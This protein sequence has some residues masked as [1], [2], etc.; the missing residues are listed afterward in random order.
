MAQDKFLIGYSD[1]ESGYQTNLKPWLINDSGFSQLEN[2]YVYRGRVR[3]RFGSTLMGLDQFSSRLRV[4]LGTVA[5]DGT[6]TATVPGTEFNTGQ[7]FSAG[8]DI[9]TV[10]QDGNPADMFVN[11]TG[12]GTYSTI[13]GMLSLADA[14][15]G[16]QVYFYPAT[17]VMGLTLYYRPVTQ[18]NVA[19]F[20]C[21][22]FDTQF[23]YKFDDVNTA[24]ERLDLGESVWT[25]SDYDF[26]WMTNYQG[27]TADLNLLWVTNNTEADGIRYLAADTWN[28]PRLNYTKGDIIGVTP[29]SGPYVNATLL[30]ADVVVGTT[31]TVGLTTFTMRD[32]SL[33]SPYDLE[34]SAGGTGTAT[35]DPTTPGAGIGTLTITG[36]FPNNSVYFT[37]D[38][39]IVTSQIIVQFRNRLLLLNTTERIN[40]VNTFFSNRM[41]Y[42]ANGSPLNADAWFGGNLGLGGA[43]DAPTVQAIV[44]VEFIKDRLIVYFENSTFELAYTGNQIDPFVWQKI[45]TELGAQSTFS[46]IPFDKAV[47]G[48]DDVG[49]HACNGANVERIDQKIPETVFTLNTQFSGVNRVCGIRDYL[50][51]L[52]LWSCPSQNRTNSFYFPNK[53][54]VYNYVNESWSLFDDSFTT[55]G[56]FLITPTSPG[57]TWG[58]TTIKWGENTALWNSNAGST[59]NVKEKRIIAGNQQGFVSI[60]QQDVTTNASV[61]QITNFTFTGIAGV[62]NV[63]CVDHNLEFLDYIMVK[64]MAGLTFTDSDDNVLPEVIVQVQSNTLLDGTP[65]S[66]IGIMVDNTGQPI[67]CTGEYLGGGTAARVSVMAALTKQYNFYTNQDRNAMVNRV[68]FLVD[69]TENGAITVDSFISSTNISMI[70]DLDVGLLPGTNVLETS[71]YLLSTFEQF[72]TRLWHP[73]YFYADGECVQ[74][75]IASSQQQIIGYDVITLEDDTKTYL[76]VSSADFQLHA[77]IFY[78]SPTSYGMQ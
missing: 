50:T 16:A 28:K 73:L 44:T 43:I 29:G 60:I 12:T 66:F 54:L 37:G 31:F 40:G 3:K 24:W 13:D 68:D 58:D 17:P 39:Y 75:S 8:M 22:G 77:M 51:E 15:I 78:A 7:M 26:F 72:Q 11:G 32:S 10:W 6:F 53:I 19:A 34:V 18:V 74:L 70:N 36:A 38:N 33:V 9:F 35:F 63:S 46:E 64:N 41:R 27:A 30:V 20:D 21:I 23:S 4:L 14:S 69:K 61:L 2:L 56:Y 49:I 48:V 57:G 42:C 67:V 59:S 55:F 52:A 5:G 71:P 47:L 1:N 62:V 76:Y 65:N 45:N 25:G